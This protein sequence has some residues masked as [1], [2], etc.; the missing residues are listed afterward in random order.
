MTDGSG[1][2][3]ISKMTQMKIGDH[4]YEITCKPAGQGIP[5]LPK[6]FVDGEHVTEPEFAAALAQP[7]KSVSPSLSPSDPT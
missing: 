4:T 6:Y 2:R 7:V 3:I 5:G 1:G